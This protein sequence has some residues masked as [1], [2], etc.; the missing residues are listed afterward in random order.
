M[1]QYAQWSAWRPIVKK[2]KIYVPYT[3]VVINELS[4]DPKKRAQF[5]SNDKNLAKCF[6]YCLQLLMN[7][8]GKWT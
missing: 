8:V 1:A 2:A 7:K 5:F 4:L 3:L 6:D